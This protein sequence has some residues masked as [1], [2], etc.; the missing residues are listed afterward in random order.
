MFV[1]A[2][3]T[4]GT[5]SNAYEIGKRSQPLLSKLIRRIRDRQLRIT[6][7]GASGTGKST[8]GKL[9]S[10]EFGQED[11]LQSYQASYKTEELPLDS[12][13]TGVISVLPGQSQFWAEEL[14]KITDGQ[15]DLLINVVAA[16]YHSIGQAD[17]RD[18]TGYQAG[19]TPRE[20]MVPYGQGKQVVELELLQ[21][22]VPHLLIAGQRKVQMITL[23]TKQDLWWSDR[24]EV[25]KFY[26]SGS[27]SQSIQEIQSHLGQNNFSH[28]YFSASL[29]TE[30][31]T[32]G[33]G[34]VLAA[35]TEGYDQRIQIINFNHFLGY[36]ESILDLKMER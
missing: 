3:N 13:T 30:N 15:V 26:E 12:R 35:V 17:Y 16:G 28:A 34:L 11:I 36:L 6:I 33:A 24:Q 20:T 27:Y 29:L 8:L 32:D 21:L 1:E 2:I 5:L 4:V 18:L 23:V 14:R 22:L 19:M 31:L 25:R 10:G 7:F 9:L